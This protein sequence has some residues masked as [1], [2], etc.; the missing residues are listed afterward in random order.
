MVTQRGEIL[1]YRRVLNVW[2]TDYATKVEGIGQKEAS[3]MEQING[4]QLLA[5]QVSKHA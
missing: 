5:E 2:S 3:S 1:Q 4:A